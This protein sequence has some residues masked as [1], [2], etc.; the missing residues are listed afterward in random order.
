MLINGVLLKRAEWFSITNF[1]FRS[2]RYSLWNWCWP[3]VIALGLGARDHCTGL[4]RLLYQ[5]LAPALGALFSDGFIRRRELA[6]RIVR[7]T[8]ERV[9][10]AA[11][12]LLNQIAFFAVGALHADEV[13]FD[14]LALGVSGAGDEFTV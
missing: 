1:I 9:A 13:L 6:L 12:F 10:T 8:V 11:G 4:E 3:L 7:A 2:L 5:V 14:V